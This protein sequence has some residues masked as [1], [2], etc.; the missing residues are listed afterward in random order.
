MYEFKLLLFFKWNKM[1]LVLMYFLD[2][3]EEIFLLYVLIMRNEI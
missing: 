1:V 3:V 2:E